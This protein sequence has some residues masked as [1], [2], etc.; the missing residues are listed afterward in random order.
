MKKYIALVVAFIF[1][2]SLVGCSSDEPKRE[3]TI[4]ELKV[5]A[6]KG[7]NISWS[8]FEPYIYSLEGGSGIHFRTYPIGDEYVLHVEGGLPD[9]ILSVRLSTKVVVDGSLNGYREIDI[10]TESIDEFL[11]EVNE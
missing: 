11:R 5:I 6:E 8:D 7:E 9:W 3:L 1:V 2:L 10:R 4:D